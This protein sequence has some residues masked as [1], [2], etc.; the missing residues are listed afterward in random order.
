MDFLLVSL[1]ILLI[2]FVQR[3]RWIAKID[4]IDRYHATRTPKNYLDVL[5]AMHLFLFYVYLLYATKNV[6]IHQNTGVFQ[7]YQV[8]GFTNGEYYI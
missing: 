8:T 6:Q 2:Y 7:A 5:A 1:F 3:N 4:E